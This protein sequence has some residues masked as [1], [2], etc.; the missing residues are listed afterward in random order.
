METYIIRIWRT[1]DPDHCPEFLGVV[2]EFRHEETGG[3]APGG[4]PDALLAI[5]GTAPSRRLSFTS[6]EQFRRILGTIGLTGEC[7]P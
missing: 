3:P 6:M 1:P 4:P 2:D 7:G 5:V